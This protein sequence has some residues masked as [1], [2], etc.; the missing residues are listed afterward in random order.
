MS[1]R[2]QIKIAASRLMQRQQFNRLFTSRIVHLAGSPMLHDVYLR[3]SLMTTSAAEVLEAI[4]GDG[5]DYTD[6]FAKVRGQLDTGES[7][8]PDEYGVEEET[9]LLLYGL[10]RQAK[11]AVLLEVGV[12][13]GRSTQV[14]LS[15]LDANKAGQLVSVDIDPRVGGPARGHPRWSLRVHDGGKSSSHELRRLMKEL[16]PIDFF[17]H[18]AGHTYYEQF[19][20][21]VAAA[22]HLRPGGLFVSDDV[23]MSFA[24]LDVTRRANVTP[25]ALT[26]RRKVVGVF[27]YA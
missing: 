12:A 19:G 24:F 23:D 13:N 16:G 26:D 22:D 18:D 11:P 1:A 10:V 3:S 9:A 20:D 5:V 7:I 17:F 14:I 27:Q 6:E 15:A 25:V 8:Y 4:F 21:Y 2:D